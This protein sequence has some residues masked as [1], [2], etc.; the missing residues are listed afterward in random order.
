MTTS[1]EAKNKL[2]FVYGSIPKPEVTDPYCKI[3]CRINSMLK[4]WLLNSVTKKIYTSILYFSVAADMWKDLHTRFHKSN[5]PRLYQL[6]HQLLFLCQ[7]TMD[8]SSYHTQTQTYWEELSS[9]QPIGTTV[10]DLLAQRESNRVIDF[11]MGLNESYDHVCSQTH[12]EDFA[13]SI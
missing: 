13:N 3:Q 9:I 10:E 2:G 7:C 6:R 5:L 4:S 11:L 8:L 1:L 12:E